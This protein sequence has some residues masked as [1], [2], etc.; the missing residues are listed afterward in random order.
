M[1]SDKL[2][3]FISLFLYLGSWVYIGFWAY[4]H[5]QM[6]DTWQVITFIPFGLF[7]LFMAYNKMKK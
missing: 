1:N 5:K 4:Y 2:T 6:N 7:S 3:G